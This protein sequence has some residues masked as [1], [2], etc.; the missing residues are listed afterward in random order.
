MRFFYVRV[1][2]CAQYASMNELRFL[3]TPYV[4]KT[5]HW[6]TPL[7]A[8]VDNVNV[9]MRVVIKVRRCMLVL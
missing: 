8:S 1:R 5:H 7:S 9:L 4:I 3:N 6:K 2:T